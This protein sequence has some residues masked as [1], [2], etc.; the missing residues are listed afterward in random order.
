MFSLEI[1]LQTPNSASVSGKNG[2]S[3]ALTQLCLINVFTLYRN[4]Y[5][6][7]S[8]SMSYHLISTNYMILLKRNSCNTLSS[9]LGFL[10][11]DGPKPFIFAQILFSCS[12][13]AVQEYRMG[14]GK[15]SF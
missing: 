14:G 15:E 4:K 6:N 3:L 2:K 12:R 5:L 8:V 10:L 13:E 9:L 7:C 1:L 11:D